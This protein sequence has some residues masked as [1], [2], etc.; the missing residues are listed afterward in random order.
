MPILYLA[1]HAEHAVAERIA[2]FRG[3]PLEDHHLKEFGRRLALVSVTVPRELAAAIADLCDPDVLAAYRIRPDELAARDL[4]VSQTVALTLHEKGFAGLRWWSALF[5]E[6]HTIVLF[7]DR[8]G[9][10]DLGFGRATP[11]TLDHPV[12]R[13]AASAVGMR[14]R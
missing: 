13:A 6:W 5:G 1:E 14:I 11:L 2:R 3:T 9:V 10:A 8:I 7:L 4:T 12:V